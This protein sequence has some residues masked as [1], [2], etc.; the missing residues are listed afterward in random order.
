MAVTSSG[1]WRV[2][3]LPG[4]GHLRDE[5]VDMVRRVGGGLKEP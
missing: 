4:V 3:W 2:D 5:P 1:L